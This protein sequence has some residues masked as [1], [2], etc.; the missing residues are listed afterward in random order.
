MTPCGNNFEQTNF[1]LLKV[2]QE[3]KK[4]LVSGPYLTPNFQMVQILTP[5]KIHPILIF[6]VENIV[7]QYHQYPYVFTGDL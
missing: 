5:K 7:E 2:P 6:V 4:M 3:I 1:L